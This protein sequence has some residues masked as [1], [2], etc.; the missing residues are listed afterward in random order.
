VVEDAVA[1][2]D[3]DAAI[4]AEDI[5]SRDVAISMVGSRIMED[6]EPHSRDP[7]DSQR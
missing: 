4:M 6:M 1:V 3:V 2:G 7:E 5:I